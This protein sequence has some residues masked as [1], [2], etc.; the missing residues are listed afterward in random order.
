MGKFK[1]YSKIWAALILLCMTTGVVIRLNYVALALAHP[2]QNAFASVLVAPPGAKK[3]ARTRILF[4]GDINLGRCI[5]KKTIRANEYTHDYAYPFQ[6]VAEELRSADITVG[7]LDSAVSNESPPTPCPQS[8]NLIGPARMAEGL[9]FAGFDVITIATNHVKDCGEKGFECDNQALFDTINNLA[10]AGAKPVGA[11]K[12]LSESRLPVIIERQGI[13]FAFLGIDQIEERIWATENAP[14]VAPLS[15]NTLEQVKADIASAKLLADVVIVL[16]HWGVEY[17][18]QPVEIQR[19]WAKEFIDAGADL[20]V[21]NH[22]HIV[23]PM[24]VLPRG[25]V[26]YALGNFVFDQEQNFRRESVV[27]EVNFVGAQIQSWALRPAS[28]NFYTFQ[29][30]WANGS[31]ADYIVA[32]VKIP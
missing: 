22:P 6:F 10:A 1:K 16:P 31:E 21:G 23:Q 25:L 9:Q 7:S 24:E 3:D 26:F 5:A 17:A 20:V 19:N 12:T 32:R 4:T 30:H 18:A 29:P 2:I 15:Q 13:R 27:V 14:G 28:I 11:G 8:M